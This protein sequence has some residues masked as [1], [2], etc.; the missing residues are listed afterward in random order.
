MD[1]A[2][3]SCPRCKR[4][5]V[6]GSLCSHC[7]FD[8][9]SARRASR[10]AQILTRRLILEPSL[11]AGFHRPTEKA[12]EIIAEQEE[13][14]NNLV[15]LVIWAEGAE[16]VVDSF[17][18]KVYKAVQLVREWVDRCGPPGVDKNRSIA[19]HLDLRGVT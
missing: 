19:V 17:S 18:D 7:G 16:R 9:S 4:A 2:M 14:I 6:E 11:D 1:T 3:M 13:L 10:Y 12:K 15:P 8:L 5:D